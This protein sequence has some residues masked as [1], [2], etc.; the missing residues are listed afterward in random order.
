MKRIVMLFALLVSL[1]AATAG[2]QTRV[3]VS[4]GF[5]VPRPYVSGYVVLG[6]PYYY[7]YHRPYYHR[8]YRRPSL[9][10]V[11]PEVIVVPRRAHRGHHRGRGRW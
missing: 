1:G 8:Y 3:S 7:R 2:A 4:V 10:M 9:V 11:R 6:E 5:G